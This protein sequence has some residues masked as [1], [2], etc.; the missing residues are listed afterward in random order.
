MPLLRCM[1]KGR[2]TRVVTGVDGLP[3]IEDGTE[4]IIGADLRGVEDAQVTSKAHLYLDMSSASRE[5]ALLT[6]RSFTRRSCP[7]RL[8]EG[9]LERFLWHL[10]PR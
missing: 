1:M 8:E 6:I 2:A 4:Q 10:Y 5:S 7:H 9:E 3:A